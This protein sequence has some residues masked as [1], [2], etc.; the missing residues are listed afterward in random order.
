MHI[1]ELLQK[2]CKL[3]GD[4]V[5]K[6]SSN[7]HPAIRDLYIRY[8]SIS[9]GMALKVVVCIQYMAA[10]WTKIAHT[11]MYNP[12]SL[13]W[14]FCRWFQP[15]HPENCLQ[16]HRMQFFKM[17]NRNKLG[18]ETLIWF[19]IE[20]FSCR[21]PFADKTV[22]MCSYWECS[23]RETVSNGAYGINFTRA[24]YD[25]CQGRGATQPNIH[26]F[27]FLACTLQLLHMG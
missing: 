1:F 13:G 12:F 17:I 26:W 3:L 24:R 9:M 10:G 7:M 16:A 11:S 2:R 15:H 22:P 25:L 8:C 6:Q 19:P 23:D 14:V 18:M 21:F 27:T 5:A 20:N 4:L